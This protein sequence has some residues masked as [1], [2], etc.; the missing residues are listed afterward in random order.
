[1]TNGSQLAF[2]IFP[3]A[4]ENSLR[5]EADN[6]V[7]M[8]A[9]VGIGTQNP[10]RPLHIQS[11]DTSGIFV[12]NTTAAVAS[13]AMLALKNSGSAQITMEDTDEGNKWRQTAGRRFV[14]SVNN[15][16]QLF[17]L[18]NAGNLELTGTITTTGG[19][20]GSGCDAVF[21]D[22]Y[23]M[24]SI[25]EHA[26]EMWE[27]GFLPNVGP[28]AENAPINIT[29]KVGRM[30]N[31]LEKAHIYIDQLNQENKD[32]QARLERLEQQMQ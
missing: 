5:I 25:E 32:L 2:R 3:G 23:E 24:P 22:G 28:T 21:E 10:T 18:D 14:I 7:T 27:S 16:A 4:D 13:R 29:D 6:D 19:T 15:S 26:A 12:E 11:V 1:V 8:R 31:E 30:L 9:N 17:K 20:C